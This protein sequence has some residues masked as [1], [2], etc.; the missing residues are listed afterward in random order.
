M[1]LHLQPLTC[2][3]MHHYY[4]ICSFM[5]AIMVPIWSQENTTPQLLFEL[6]GRCGKNH[7]QSYHP[8]LVTNGA[9]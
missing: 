6:L 7:L 5:L 4:Y 8:L 3:Q 2:Q 9:L 1:E